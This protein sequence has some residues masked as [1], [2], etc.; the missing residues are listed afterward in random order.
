MK[1]FKDYCKEQGYDSG[2]LLM[3]GLDR[4]CD[5]ADKYAQQKAEMFAE[6]IE[7]NNWFKAVTKKDKW[8]CFATNE[9]FTT[10]ELYQEYLKDYKKDRERQFE[11]E[12]IPVNIDDYI[13]LRIIEYEYPKGEPNRISDVLYDELTNFYLWLKSKL[14][15]SSVEQQNTCPV[16]CGR[17]LVPV[18]FYLSQTNEL[19]S[20]TGDEQCR[21]CN[22]TGIIWHEDNQNIAGCDKLELEQKD[23]P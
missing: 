3:A 23:K 16:C 10:S 8:I 4:V 2:N 19:G 22:G 20:I 11:K 15:Y 13:H 9:E 18:D 1:I 21:S 17:G 12:S 6:W 5:M 14:L 7:E